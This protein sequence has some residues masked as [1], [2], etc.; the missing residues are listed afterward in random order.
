M[1]ELSSCNTWQRYNGLQKFIAYQPSK[2]DPKKLP[3]LEF[4]E[5]KKKLV[6]PTSRQLLSKKKIVV[7]SSNFTKMG[8]FWEQ[9]AT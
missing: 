2:L 9:N 6:I 5:E 1:R 3:S 7:K 8:W 4:K